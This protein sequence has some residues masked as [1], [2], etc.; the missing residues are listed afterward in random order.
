MPGTGSG[1]GGSYVSSQALAQG[2]H[3]FVVDW[4][5]DS[6]TW[7]MDDVPR[8]STT[9]MFGVSAPDVH[10][11]ESGDRR[12]GVVAGSTQWQYGFP[13]GLRDQIR[14]R[15]C[16]AAAESVGRGGCGQSDLCGADV[17]LEQRPDERDGL[18][19]GIGGT[20]DQFQYAYVPLQGDGTI[21]A[22]VANEV[23]TNSTSPLSPA[24]AANAG[25]WLA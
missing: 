12:R 20:S 14:P 8:Y 16:A 19:G 5:P 21:I 1:L 22:R 2:F 17:C 23:G 13:F 24:G 4:E 6:I 7:Y 9:S 3:K 15:L 25:R 10:A 18:R 11:A